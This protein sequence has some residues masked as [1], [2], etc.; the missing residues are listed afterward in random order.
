MEVLERIIKSVAFAGIVTSKSWAEIVQGDNT[1][2]GGKN[3]IVN[4]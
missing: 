1:L 3:K 4:K 2:N